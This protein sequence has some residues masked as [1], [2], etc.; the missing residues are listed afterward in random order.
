MIVLSDNTVLV[1]YV[2]ASS[3]VRRYATDGST[4]MDY[5]LP[6]AGSESSIFQSIT[7]T[8]SFWVRVHDGV[9]YGTGSCTCYEIKLSDGSLLNT[10]PQASYESGLYLPTAS[11]TP[12][13][14]FG[15]SPSC[16]AFIL[17]EAIWPPTP[18]RENP[19]NT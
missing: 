15:L 12:L 18:V 7:P 1:M 6:T 8:I 16:P 2:G 4:V 11:T 10:I 3:F 9:I 14:R 17:R 13:A 5:S 19:L